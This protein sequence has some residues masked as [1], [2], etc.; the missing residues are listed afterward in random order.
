MTTPTITKL[1]E[2]AQQLPEKIPYLKMLVLFGSRATGD[3]HA[4]SDWDFAVL[5]DQ[6][7]RE[8]YVKDNAFLLFEL[9]MV[10]GKVF[11]INSDQIDIVELNQCSELISHFVARDGK[12]LYE[13]NP[14]EFE[15]FKQ[16]MLLS[17]SELKKIEHLKR[18]NIE[19]F[20]QR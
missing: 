15:K 19:K 13:D 8:A 16:K 20:L 18:R 5:C 1:R 11:K 9:P 4:K 3:I 2:F 7:Q 10:L 6:E 17:N 12:V 14:E